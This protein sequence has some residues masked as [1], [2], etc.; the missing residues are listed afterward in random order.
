MHFKDILF[1]ATVCVYRQ[2]GALIVYFVEII[3]KFM[4]DEPGFE[5]Q[6]FLFKIIHVVVVMNK[7]IEPPAEH[8]DDV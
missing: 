4:L 7:G 5:V 6:G 1:I 8:G 3:G 2:A